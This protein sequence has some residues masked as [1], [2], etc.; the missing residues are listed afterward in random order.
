MDDTNN[1]QVA[2]RPQGREVSDMES[3]MN[4][5]ERLLRRQQDRL[6]QEKAN[7]EEA[8]VN[9]VNAYAAQLAKLERE[10]AD[11]AHRLLLEHNAKVGEIERLI[12]KLKAMREA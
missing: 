12:T 10:T 1:E 9:L 4:T 7:Y 3:L 11:S 8:R 2:L 6:V 5:G